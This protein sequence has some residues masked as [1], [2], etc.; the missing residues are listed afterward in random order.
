MFR[1]VQIIPG[2]TTFPVC[3]TC[4]ALSQYPESTAAREPPTTVMELKKL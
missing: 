3:P 1:S 2:A 4:I